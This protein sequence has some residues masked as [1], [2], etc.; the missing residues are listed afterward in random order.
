MHDGQLSDEPVKHGPSLLRDSLFSILQASLFL[1]AAAALTL[2]YVSYRSADFGQTF[3]LAGL[4]LTAPWFMV[5]LLPALF[6]L[7][8]SE[9]RREILVRQIVSMLVIVTILIGL[10]I[11]LDFHHE[12]WNQVASTAHRFVE[13]SMD[14]LHTF[15]IFIG[16]AFDFLATLFNETL[17]PLFSGSTFSL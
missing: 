5:S 7:G 17:L 10:S 16:T 8:D 15:I 12:L 2:F 13:F 11:Y 3:I 1:V 6:G 4:L 9:L 14:G